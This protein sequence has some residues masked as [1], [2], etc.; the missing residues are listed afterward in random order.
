MLIKII[1][2]FEGGGGTK[3]VGILRTTII[4][5]APEFVTAPYT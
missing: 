1:L 3:R 4:H 2:I 5:T